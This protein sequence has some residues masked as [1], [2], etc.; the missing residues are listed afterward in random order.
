MHFW[1]VARPM[2][3]S[4]PAPLQQLSAPATE[5]KRS[6][7]VLHCDGRS[8]Y[9]A[10]CLVVSTLWALVA[11]RPRELPCSS[12]SSLSSSS[13]RSS[14]LQDSVIA[15][16]IAAVVTRVVG[17]RTPAAAPRSRLPDLC[18]RPRHHHGQ[19]EGRVEKEEQGSHVSLSP[20][21]TRS[22]GGAAS[23]S[24]PLRPCRRSAR[25]PPRPQL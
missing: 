2:A 6:K 9:F 22:R 24:L 20:L 18:P 19:E 5:S 10:R 3:G 23:R 13:S 17:A 11:S 21:P 7:V 25:R 4:A 15:S 8:R 1:P 14:N 12:A 16:R